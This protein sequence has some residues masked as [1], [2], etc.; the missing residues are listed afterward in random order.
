[1]FLSNSFL[2]IT[3]TYLC[4]VIS[5]AASKMAAYAQLKENCPYSLVVNKCKRLNHEY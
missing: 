2:F 4:V 3:V 1:M 5:I